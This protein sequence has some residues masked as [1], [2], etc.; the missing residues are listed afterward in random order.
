MPIH[1]W[2]LVSAGDFHD[3][4]QVWTGQIRIALNEG[5]LA[6]GYYAQIEHQAS[7]VL[8]D[9]LTLRY[10]DWEG[11]EEDPAATEGTLAVAVAP[12]QV[13]IHAEL[14]RGLYAE[15]KN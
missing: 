14:E 8:P 9:G 7:G 5:I 2:T 13:S 3:F 6:A 4:H 1:D 15:M 12:P 11:A 10:A